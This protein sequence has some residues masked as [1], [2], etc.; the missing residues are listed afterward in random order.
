MRLDALVDGELLFDDGSTVSADLVV[1]AD[2]LHST[3]RAELLEDGE[4]RDA[5]LVAF[6]GV[7]ELDAP[8]PAGEW[9]GPGSVAGLLP[10][11]RPL[12]GPARRTRRPAPA[13][14]PGVRNALVSRAE[15]DAIAS[16]GPLRR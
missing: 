6:R 2:G 13:A 16:A 8:V 9:W 1:G 14:P 5:S 7:A 11:G 10:C 15:I 4:P 3:V 12:R